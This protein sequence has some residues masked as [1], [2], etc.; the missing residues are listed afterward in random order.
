M[1]Y[2]RVIYNHN[3]NSYLIIFFDVFKKSRANSNRLLF[4]NSLHSEKKDSDIDKQ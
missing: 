3:S 4:A 2:F 1:G